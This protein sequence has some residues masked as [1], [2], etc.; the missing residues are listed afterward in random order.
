MS[1]LKPENTVPTGLEVGWNRLFVATP[2]LRLGVGATLS[3]FPR[4]TPPGSSPVLQVNN[5]QNIENLG[6]AITSILLD[7]YYFV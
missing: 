7:S 1:K 5:K 6:F 2:R 4:N 3:T